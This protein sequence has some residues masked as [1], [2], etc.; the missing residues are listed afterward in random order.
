M[1]APG[2][3]VSLAGAFG[4]WKG[5]KELRRKG[6]ALDRDHDPGYLVGICNGI[7]QGEAV[8]QAADDGSRVCIAGSDGILH[9]IGGNGRDQIAGPVF[10]LSLI[11]I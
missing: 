5:R 6:R 11:H 7:P 9:M 4:D 3:C 2:P 10:F 1:S 8:G